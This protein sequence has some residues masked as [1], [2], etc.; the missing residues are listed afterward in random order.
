[1]FILGL[2]TWSTSC[3]YYPNLKLKLFILTVIY[4]MQTVL[5]SSFVWCLILCG[6]RW[7]GMF[8][9]AETCTMCQPWKL[10]KRASRGNSPFISS[11]IN[12]DVASQVARCNTRGRNVP[13]LLKAVVILPLQPKQLI[14]TYTCCSM[15]HWFGHIKVVVVFLVLSN[16]LVS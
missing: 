12:H 16:E 6:W 11:C 7:S 10:P 15:W 13:C 1:M 8:E 3:F 14:K 5:C 9:A 4:S 2:C